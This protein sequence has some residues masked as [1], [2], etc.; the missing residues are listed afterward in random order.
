MAAVCAKEFS[1]CGGKG[2]QG[3]KCCAGLTCQYH[4]EYY[5]QCLTPTPSAVPSKTST[6]KTLTPSPSEK[7]YI[8]T[9]KTPSV[10]SPSPSPSPT[11]SSR[12][13]CYIIECDPSHPASWCNDDNELMKDDSCN[14]NKENCVTCNGVW[15]PWSPSPPKTTTPSPSPSSGKP[16]TPPSKPTSKCDKPNDL[17]KKCDGVDITDIQ[18]PVGCCIEGTVCTRINSYYYQCLSSCQSSEK[19]CCDKNKGPPSACESC[20]VKKDACVQGGKWRRVELPENGMGC[21]YPWTDSTGNVNYTY[22]DGSA[23]SKVVC[24]HNRGKWMERKNCSK[25]D[26]PFPVDDSSFDCTDDECSLNAPIPNCGDVMESEKYMYFPSGVKP[27]GYTIGAGK[28]STVPKQTRIEKCKRNLTSKNGWG[29]EEAETICK[30]VKWDDITS[31][32][33]ATTTDFAFGSATSCM[34]DGKKVMEELISKKIDEKTWI[35]VATPSWAQSPFN[36]TST[37]G[38]AQGGST[39]AWR[40]NEEYTSNC[41]LGKAGCGRCW[42]LKEIGGEEKEANVVVID[43]CEDANAYGNNYNWCV[44]TRPDTEKHTLNPKSAYEGHFPPFRDRMVQA[45]SNGMGDEGMKWEAEDCYDDEGRFICTNM[46]GAPLHFDFAIQGMDDDVL[47][48]AGIWRT[49]TNPRV[50]AFPQKCPEKVLKVLKN[51]C[52]SNSGSTAKPEEY[53]PGNDTSK[54]LYWPTP[55]P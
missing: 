29:E 31:P 17:F 21:C 55:T 40:Y 42:F 37:S 24:N 27:V 39:P 51:H 50:M 35:G 16:Y 52:G 36:T 6:P 18:G 47:D 41:S 20:P 32:I 43:S 44:A 5:S 38:K 53:C 2:Y 4:N 34:C 23:C 19:E 22:D 28:F 15:A 25:N 9:S 1:Q 54:Q 7:P 46:D 12:M 49:S 13:K 3:P 14:K 10:P 45:S 8:P 26:T 48:A 11:S 30:G 33:P